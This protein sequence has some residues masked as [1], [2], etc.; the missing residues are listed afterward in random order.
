M[1]NIAKDIERVLLSEKEIASRV[2]E[3][4]ADI[5]KDYSGKNPLLIRIWPAFCAVL[6]PVLMKTAR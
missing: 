6:S 5:A 2:T 3:I 4:S 1:D